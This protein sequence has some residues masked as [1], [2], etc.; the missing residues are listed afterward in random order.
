LALE[1]SDKTV[2]CQRVRAALLDLDQ[3]EQGTAREALEA[4]IASCEAC[5][6][7]WGNAERL[8]RM[9]RRALHS[10]A[11]ADVCRHLD[12]VLKDFAGSNEP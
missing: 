10:E 12:E 4:H 1:D 11:P 2:T 7:A 5:R 9:A 6:R 8:L 3:M